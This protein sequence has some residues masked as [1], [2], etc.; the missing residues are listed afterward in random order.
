MYL[1]LA[2][3]TTLACHSWGAQTTSAT[4]DGPLSAGRYVDGSY[5][6]NSGFVPDS[7]T[8]IRIAEAVLFP[9]YGADHVRSQRPFGAKLHEG[10]WTVWGYLP[11]NHL[12]GV[13][14]VQI[15]KGD[16]RILKLTHGK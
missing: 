11:P 5:L 8:A 1:S 3:V 14:E 10:V 7:I 6:P 12:G 9:I 2:I 4:G 13:A 15:A 16:A